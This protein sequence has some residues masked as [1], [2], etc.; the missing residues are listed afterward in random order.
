[1]DGQAREG[2]RAVASESTGYRFAI[3][4]CRFLPFRQSCC[5]SERREAATQPRTL[6]G[7]GQLSISDLIKQPAKANRSPLP[8]FEIDTPSPFC[9]EDFGRAR[10]QRTS[11]ERKL[12]TG[13][14]SSSHLS[15]R[16]ASSSCLVSFG[17]GS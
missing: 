14:N 9:D 8:K 5:H 10:I 2:E 3:A 13:K 11:M 7:R 17:T 12:W 6:S 4:D 16:S 1:M 15:P